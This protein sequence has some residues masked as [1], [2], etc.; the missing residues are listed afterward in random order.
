M[1][2]H[3]MEIL[4]MKANQGDEHA[5]ASLLENVEKEFIEGRMERRVFLIDNGYLAL[6]PEEKQRELRHHLTDKIEESEQTVK[7]FIK[8][9]DY[10]GVNFEYQKEEFAHVIRYVNSHFSMIYSLDFIQEFLE[11]WL[12]TFFTFGLANLKTPLFSEFINNI[13]TLQNHGIDDSAI[14]DIFLNYITGAIAQE[15]SKTLLHFILDKLERIQI[16]YATDLFERILKEIAEK[17]K[18]D[19]CDDYFVNKS[20]ALLHRL[21]DSELYGDGIVALAN[22]VSTIMNTPI[23]PLIEEP[24]GD[25]LEKT[26]PEP[27]YEWEEDHEVEYMREV[28]HTKKEKTAITFLPKSRKY[29][30]KHF[31]RRIALY[32]FLFQPRSP[33]D[34]LTTYPFVRDGLIR[35]RKYVEGFLRRKVIL[36]DE[37]KGDL[38]KIADTIQTFLDETP[39][40]LEEFNQQ[41]CRYDLKTI[42]IHL[43]DFEWNHRIFL[44]E[45]SGPDGEAGE[46]IWTFE[47]AEEL[48]NM[49]I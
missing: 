22:I 40:S 5:K 6:F 10:H 39:D 23:A 19:L 42:S 31:L 2:T 14:R 17:K 15:G 7:E 16:L 18:F 36:T 46:L 20:T 11:D 3:S 30:V 28:I 34:L 27:Y 49:L 43:R 33:E 9:M 47:A 45:S 24:L 26:L 35:L 48:L 1:N 41:K 21:G 13:F 44:F 4:K 37:Q 32:L 12:G 25:A 29:S 38:R 8:A